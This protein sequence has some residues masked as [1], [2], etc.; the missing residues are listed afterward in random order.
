VHDHADA[1]RLLT[2]YT[3][4]D[5]HQQALRDN[6]L[7][8]LRTHPNGTRRECLPDHLTASALVV[9]PANERVLLGLHAKAKL[10]L[11][12]GGHI[13]ADDATIA[14]AALR[15]A[16]EESGIVGLRLWS[17][18]PLRLDRHPA[19]CSPDAR[20]HLDVQFM[21][22]APPGAE[23]VLSPEQLDL[24]WCPYDELAEPTDGAVR[25]LVAAAKNALRGRASPAEVPSSSAPRP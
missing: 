23:P 13:E 25:R 2:A 7:T 5:A 8:H 14:A 20:Y 17:E 21:A 24:R 18:L 19:P 9:D 10:W 11:Q 12:M 1:I 4:A 15:E 6:Y 16:T 3:P 22:V